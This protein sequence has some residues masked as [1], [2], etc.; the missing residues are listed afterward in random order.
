[1]QT[2]R[3]SFLESCANVGIGYGIAVGS[4]MA[5]FPLFGVRLPVTDNLLIGACFTLVSLGRSYVLRRV[6]ARL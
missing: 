2:R 5:I 1:M 6:F 4:Q 3:M